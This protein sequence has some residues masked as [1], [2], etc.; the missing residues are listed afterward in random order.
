MTRKRALILIGA[1]AV[2]IGAI[3]AAIAYSRPKVL[4]AS[5]TVE[6]RNIHVGSK[7]GGRIEKVL[8]REGDRV[9]A[10][11][12]LVTFED[13]ELTA[14]LRDAQGAVEQA[15]ANYEMMA[16]GYRPE[17]V[18]EA[19]ATA[20]QAKA[21]LDAYQRGYRQE[22][23]AQSKADLDRARAQAVNAEQNYARAKEL[24][25]AGVFSRQQLDDATA[26][27]DAAQAELRSS[28]ERAQEFS[29]GYRAEDV[30]AAKAKFQQSDALRK[31]AE[32]GYRPEE[33]AA[34]KAQYERAQATLLD[35]ETK[36]KER[37]VIA[38]AAATVE[39][40]DVRPGDL[41][42]PNAPIALLLE[43]DQTYV[44]VYIPETQFG[45]IR[46]GQE[47]KLRVDAF[48]KRTFRGTVEQ[49]NQRAEYLP[50]NVQTR[51][52]RAHQVVGVK[53]RLNDPESLIR[54]GMSADVEMRPEG[55]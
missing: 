6:A 33:I 27:R 37:Q 29:T 44:R 55:Q 26:A 2:L 46:L 25:S 50:R 20:E 13:Q 31:R 48:P 41:I 35:A 7:V 36:Y 32:H 43:R 22:Q 16:R 17:D 53:V 42:S 34:A 14:K 19:R 38:P 49:I 52:E 4:R 5:G 9:E 23:V 21:S 24:A 39:V 15:K 47:A 54:S 30:E 40:L 12:V 18:A 8:V 3:S 51:E 45:L 28:E 11:Q 10:G 1:A